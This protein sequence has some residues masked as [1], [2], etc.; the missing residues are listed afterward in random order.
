MRLRGSHRL[1]PFNTGIC[2]IDTVMTEQILPQWPAK[3]TTNSPKFDL[4]KSATAQGQL[5]LHFN[6]SAGRFPWMKIDCSVNVKALQK[7]VFIY[8]RLIIIVNCTGSPQSFHYINSYTSWIKYPS[9]NR[10]K[11][12][13]KKQEPH[14]KSLSFGNLRLG[15]KKSGE[16]GKSAKEISTN[17]NSNNN[18]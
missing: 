14:K 6:A 3:P 13:P 18:N 9:H 8:W 4:S 17:N 1:H 15:K 11:K 16:W 12:H 7:H 2:L 5:T 10:S